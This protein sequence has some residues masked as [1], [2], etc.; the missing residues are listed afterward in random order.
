MFSEPHWA[1]G[2]SLAAD[3]GSPT[4]RRAIGYEIGLIEAAD[5]RI[6]DLEIVGPRGRAALTQDAVQVIIFV[7]RGNRYSGV[8]RTRLSKP[9]EFA[10]DERNGSVNV[11]V[12]AASVPV[13]RAQEKNSGTRIVADVCAELPFVP[14]ER[15]GLAPRAVWI[16]EM[17]RRSHQPVADAVS[18]DEIRCGFAT[19][20]SR[21]QAAPAARALIECAHIER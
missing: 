4:R 13:F 6:D 11:E 17:L 14:V 15:A 19:L 20:V 16:V 21:R 10:V 5:K 3:I 7:F 9:Q 2:I 12:P 8:S 1:R 18:A